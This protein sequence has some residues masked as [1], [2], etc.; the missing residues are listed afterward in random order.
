MSA[1]SSDLSAY[2]APSDPTAVVGARIGAWV[3]DLVIYLALVFA[4]SAATGGV[5]AVTYTALDRESAERIC[6][7]WEETHDGFCFVGEDADGFT[8]QTVQNGYEGLIFWAG[9]LVA[10][11]VIQGLAGGSLGKLAVGLRVVDDQGQVVGV[12]RSLVRTVAWILDALTCGLPVI[13]GVLMVST[14]GHRR[15]GDMIAGTYVVKK[16][17]VGQPVGATAAGSAEAWDQSRAGSWGTPP[18]PSWPPAGPGSAP[19]TNP[20]TPSTG[21]SPV[22]P[23]PNQST[24]GGQRSGGRTNADDGPTWDQDRNTY[25]QYDRDRSEWLQWDD[26]IQAWVPISR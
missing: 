15:L 14:K 3:I 16:A 9:H 19:A 12:G 4:F 6:D 11:S 5:E 10:Y 8:A 7:N 20:W 24:P 22:S 25:I 21:T 23:G 18:A 2:A 1:Y 17:S 13:G 26:A